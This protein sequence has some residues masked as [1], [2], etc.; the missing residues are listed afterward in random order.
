MYI[1]VFFQVMI[2]GVG[3]FASRDTLRAMFPCLGRE[4][5]YSQREKLKNV[6]TSKMNSVSDSSLQN[7]C[8]H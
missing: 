3:G 6:K 2:Y 8:F 7:K 5:F 1:Y 4:N